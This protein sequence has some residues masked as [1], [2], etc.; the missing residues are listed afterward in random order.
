MPSRVFKSSI[1]FFFPTP[2]VLKEKK[3]ILKFQTYSMVYEHV[4]LIKDL[5]NLRFDP[6]VSENA[7]VIEVLREVV[8]G[9]GLRA[10]VRDIVHLH[11]LY[12]NN[13]PVHG[14]LGARGNIVDQIFIM[15]CYCRLLAL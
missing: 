1:F 15:L 11:P 8:L 3:L 9:V 6:L 10:E 4:G 14:H 5:T 12:L 7:G 13:K 2:D